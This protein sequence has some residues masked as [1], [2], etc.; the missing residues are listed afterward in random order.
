MTTKQYAND[1]DLASA[2]QE[3]IDLVKSSWTKGALARDSSGNPVHPNS[4]SAVTFSLA[5]AIQRIAARRPQAFPLDRRRLAQSLRQHGIR[6]WNDQSHRSQ[7]DVLSLL[8]TVAQK[9]G[10]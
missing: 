4:S 1:P 6:E 3:A 9:F 10:A 2:L 7:D 8:Q 5:G